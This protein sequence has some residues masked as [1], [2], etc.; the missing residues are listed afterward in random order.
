[1][2][3]QGP[4]R[5]A[6]A[7]VF[8]AGAFALAVEPVRDFD[9]STKDNAVQARDKNSGELVWVVE[10]FDG[11][12]TARQKTLKVKIT[13]PAAPA[14]PDAL[15]GLP[16]RPVEFDG[17]TVTPYIDSKTDRLA[18]SLRAAGMRAAGKPA[19]SMPKAA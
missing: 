6:F 13:A 8:P 18:Y 2:A 5:V 4:F 16:L 1:M 15:P 17:L 12:P 7:D 3:V 14:M 19:G 10:V 11:D 9:K